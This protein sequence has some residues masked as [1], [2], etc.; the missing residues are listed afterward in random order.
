MEKFKP[1]KGVTQSKIWDLLQS[2]GMMTNEI[3][4]A[5]QE[6]T[7][8]QVMAS[9]ARMRDAG[10]IGR[11]ERG[12][13]RIGID[14]SGKKSVPIK[15]DTKVAILNILKG[16]PAK[17][18]RIVFL[19]GLSDDKVKRQLYSM[20][21]QGLIAR[22]TS[23]KWEIGLKHDGTAIAMKKV[24][25]MLEEGIYT[26][27]EIQKEIGTDRKRASQLISRIRREY[28]LSVKKVY[29]LG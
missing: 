24:L 11:D 25:S 18:S 19:S 13:W 6:K 8:R 16:G 27:E 10:H 29:V 1:R 20:R 28:G 26:I 2:G 22:N 3:I 12:V 23:G 15:S 14:D 9:L 5:I 17:A 7:G 4:S 21:R